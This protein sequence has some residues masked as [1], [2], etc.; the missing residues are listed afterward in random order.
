MCKGPVANGLWESLH[1]AR[2]CGGVP[3]ETLSF[4][5][6]IALDSTDKGEAC[7]PFFPAFNH[8][9]PTNLLTLPCER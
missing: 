7:L 3:R 2:V 9:L 5:L 8:H 1:M 6:L 4:L